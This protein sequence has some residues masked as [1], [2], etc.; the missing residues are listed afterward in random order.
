MSVDEFVN[1]TLLNPKRVV[2]DRIK[3]KKTFLEGK[4]EEYEID[5][6]TFLKLTVNIF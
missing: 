6:T 4:Q 3:E 2:F 1:R 5:K